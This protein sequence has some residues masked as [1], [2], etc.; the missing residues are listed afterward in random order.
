MKRLLAF[1]MM[2]L[3][4]LAVCTSAPRVAVTGTLS[5][6]GGPAPQDGNRGPRPLVGAQFHIIGLGKDL[7]VN[8]GPGGVFN[9]RL[10]VGHY[11]V[12]VGTPGHN[13][14]VVQPRPNEIDVTARGPNRFELIENVP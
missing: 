13:T 14:G 5:M 10:Q 1:S 11:K 6:V 12:V 2:S 7:L 3:F 9:V 8:T 4:L